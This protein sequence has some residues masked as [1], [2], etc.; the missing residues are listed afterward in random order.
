MGNFGLPSTEKPH[1]TGR[2]MLN[3]VLLTVYV[4]GTENSFNHLSLDIHLL[5]S[6]SSLVCQY[7]SILF[8]IGGKCLISHFSLLK[9]KVVVAF[10]HIVAPFTP[11]YNPFNNTSERTN[12]GNNIIHR[13]QN[14][15]FPTKFEEGGG[16]SAH[17]GVNFS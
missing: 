6:N 12:C 15:R 17:S 8:N 10:T 4:Y 14:L 13:E 1:L 2:N 5:N 3:M 11:S 16:F 7:I 9:L